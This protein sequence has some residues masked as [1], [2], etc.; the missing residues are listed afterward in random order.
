MDTAGEG[1]GRADR[2][3]SA[4][5]YTEPCKQ[6]RQLVQSCCTAQGRE[7]Q[8][9]GRYIYTR[10]RHAAV[11]QKLAQHCRTVTLQV[12]KSAIKTMQ[13]PVTVIL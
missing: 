11:W 6:S 4:D 2:G 13:V 7:A 3:G 5:G 8:R 10:L 12:K 1:E 9:E